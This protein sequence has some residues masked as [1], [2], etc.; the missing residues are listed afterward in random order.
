[1]DLPMTIKESYVIK[2]TPA[3]WGN[4]AFKEI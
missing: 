4:V 2:D 3:T 1:M